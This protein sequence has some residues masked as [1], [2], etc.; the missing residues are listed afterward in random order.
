MK[1]KPPRE[2]RYYDG[3]APS[4]V[5]AMEH[6]RL[7]RRW[8]GGNVGEPDTW[9]NWKA[10]LKAAFALDMSTAEVKFFRTVAERR[11]PTRR[12]KEL[13]IVAG[14]RAGKDSIASVV[15]GHAAAFFADIERLRPGER[16]LCM[17][18]A[19]S[20]DQSGIVLNYTKAFFEH[21]EPLQRMIVRET[22]TGFELCN[23]V[24][25]A[26]ATNSY[27]ATRGRTV[28][29]AI[30]DECAFYRDETSTNPDLELYAALKPGLATLPDSMLIGISSPYRRNGLLYNKFK[31]H[32]GRD[33][34]DVLV[35]RAPSTMLN[36][37]L[38]E[39][40][41][42]KA[43]EDDPAA[44]RAEWLA[45]F[46]ADIAGFVSQEVVDAVTVVGRHELPPTSADTYAGFCDPSGG[47]ADSMTLAIAHRG[48]DGR[49]V[50]DAVRERRPP[51][52]PDDV[53]AEFAAVLKSYGVSKVQGDRYG[54]A[55]PAERFKVHG[56]TY[57]PAEKSK[58]ELYCE[59]LPVLNSGR[60]E[61][62]D[63]ARLQA[64][65]LGLERRTSRSGKDSID[66]GPGGHDDVSNVCA[67]AVLM[68]LGHVP[69]QIAPETM[70]TI[71]SARPYRPEFSERAM[72]R[73]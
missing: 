61:L 17:A 44:A 3:E 72:G 46:R 29:L 35:I 40:I 68:V 60:C 26:V 20:R 24:E 49:A 41:I 16:A 30:L 27:R 43:L 64:Q 42:A 6:P 36:P 1:T 73:S 21:I 9:A 69:M 45:E 2:R 19:C 11:L 65:L 5:A 48:N 62:L 28:L 7:F 37:T 32:F 71:L 54:G 57:D 38:D 14:R 13:W 4:V 10:V 66:H 47:S 39:S 70:A 51:F 25:V 56:I 50:L 23:G 59:L 63:H 58:S 18:V 67:G 31:K 15:M 8:F 33:D 52:S 34:D 22:K 53:V 55:W 12:V